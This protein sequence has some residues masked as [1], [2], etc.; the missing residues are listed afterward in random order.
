M[1]KIHV[2]SDLFLGF[3]EFSIE[4]EQLPDVDLVIFNGNLGLLK[5]GML[6]VE[7]LCNKYP[8]TQFVYN[9]GQTEYHVACPKFIGELDESLTYRKLSNSSWPSNLHWSKEPMLIKL[10][11]DIIID[12]LCTYGYP[13]IH[14]YDIPW[15]ETIWYRDYVMEIKDDF[16]KE[17]KDDWSRP[18]DT[19]DVNHGLYPV[20]ATKDWINEQHLKEWKLVKNWEINIK[21]SKIL[22]THINPYKDSRCQGQT[23]SPYKI[24]L[25]NGIWIGSDTFCDKV[26]FLGSRLYSNPG[27]GSKAR[28]HVISVQ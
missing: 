2:I 25:E 26:Q 21:H 20:F 19:S 10:K 14:K 22:V 23:V 12:V 13:F 11:N 3:N 16:P 1:I 24:H 4:E 28:Q 5:R 27:R 8:D 15:E 17:K 6:Y 18:A 7:K 9:G